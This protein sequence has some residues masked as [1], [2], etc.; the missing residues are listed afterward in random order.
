MSDSRESA[1]DSSASPSAGRTAVPSGGQLAA[2]IAAVQFLTRVPLRPNPP[3]DAALL[4]RSVVYFPLV[5]AGVGLFTVTVVG[6]GIWFW[7]AWLAVVVALAAE[8]LLTGA[9]HEDALADCCDA[10]GGGWTRDQ[11]LTILKDSRL[12]TFGVVGLLLG[13][14]L[15]GG[16]MAVLVAR[17]GSSGVWLWVAAIVAAATLGRWL[18]VAAMVLVRPVAERAS[19][20][21]DAGAQLAFKELAWATLAAAPGIVGLLIAAPGQALTAALAASAVAALLLV[22]FR[23]RLDG[24]TGDCLGCIGYA[25]QTAVLLV[26]AARWSV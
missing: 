5:G 10:F 22:Q 19:L 20:S 3:V 4:R 26:M 24:I 18:I 2:L 1:V 21:R 25:G 17:D 7:P 12:G 9:F 14:G 13:I 15:R 11:I 23:R 8:A 16:A 6:A